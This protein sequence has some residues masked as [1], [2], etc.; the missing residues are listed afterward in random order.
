VIRV[1]TGLARRAYTLADFGPIGSNWSCVMQITRAADYAVRVVI[2]LA[3]LPVGVN[4]HR[5]DIAKATNVAASFLSKVLQQ[6]VQAGMVAS[7]RGSRGGFR[8][9]VAIQAISVLDVVEAIEGPIRL[10]TCL[11]PGPSCD[12]KGWCPA[13]EVWIEAQGALVNVLRNASVA[14]L[15]EKAAQAL[16]AGSLPIRA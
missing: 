16:S 12:R 7:Q 6:L 8:L 11:E 13:H 15:A 3:S 5:P 14:G 2:H 10:N 9:A 4:V 1:L